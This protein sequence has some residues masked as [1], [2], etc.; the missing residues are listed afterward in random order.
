M[1]ILAPVWRSFSVEWRYGHHHSCQDYGTDT[2]M[3]DGESIVM[4]VFRDVNVDTIDGG[5]TWESDEL[6]F[7]CLIWGVTSGWY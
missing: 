2:I 7:D 1:M 5:S 3:G 4:A 6:A